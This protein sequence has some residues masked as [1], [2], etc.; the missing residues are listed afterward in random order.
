[1]DMR[2]KVEAP[3]CLLPRG[4]TAIR[5]YD[6]MLVPYRAQVVDATPIRLHDFLNARNSRFARTGAT[7]EESKGLLDD[8]NQTKQL[9][10]ATNRSLRVTQC[11]ALI[12][13]IGLIMVA[14]VVIIV[15]VSSLNTMNDIR[16]SI[17]PHAESL[18][19]A[20]IATFGNMGGSASDVHEMTAV[21]NQ[22]AQKA[23]K[24]GGPADLAL[25]SST[26][27]VL[28]LQKFMEHPSIQ[29]SLGA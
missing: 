9:L 17:E 21:A 24:D 10:I 25:N 18:V 14:V 4:T 11:S 15:G 13:M 1:M 12:A 29:I 7:D 2:D 5:Q 3:Q 28:R 8:H 16:E 23:L 6:T 22:L 20:T 19:N 26:S 27:M